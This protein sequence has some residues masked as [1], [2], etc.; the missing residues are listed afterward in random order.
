M[1]LE[2]DLWAINKLPTH[3]EPDIWANN[4]LPTHLEPDLWAIIQ[5][6]EGG[7]Q[8]DSHLSVHYVDNKIDNPG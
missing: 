1:H 5:N 7:D 8:P 4:E 6:K 3:L 2:P